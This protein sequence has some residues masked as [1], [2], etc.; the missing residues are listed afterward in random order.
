MDPNVQE[1]L[2]VVTD[3]D[4][5][6]N[7]SD[8]K[9]NEF[10]STFE[11]RA[12]VTRYL[13]LLSAHTICKVAEQRQFIGNKH[14]AEIHESLRRADI[15]AL[16]DADTRGCYNGRVGG[17]SNA[18]LQVIAEERADTILDELPPLRQAVQVIRPEVAKKIDQRTAIIA[19]LK[20]VK[21]QLEEL[22]GDVRLSE[23]D[24]NMT[25]GDFRKS[26]KARSAKRNKLALKLK[27]LAEEGA[28]LDSD[29]HKALYRGLPGLS[30]AVAKVCQQHVERAIALD[31]TTRRVTEQVKF[32]D[33]DAAVELL[34]G[35]EKDEAAVTDEIRAEFGQAMQVLQLAGKKARKS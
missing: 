9:K 34:R 30:D 8:E 6:T 21:E 7:W 12:R 31:A 2:A 32:G 5:L 13:L 19:K 10:C 24:Q 25:I 29:I 1:V 23:L 17:R 11:S 28:E 18:E 26:I 20:E 22:G 27:D 14:V 4:A 16:W 15:N 3:D 35:F 33:S